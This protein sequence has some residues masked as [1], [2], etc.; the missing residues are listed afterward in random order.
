MKV[1]HQDPLDPLMEIPELTHGHLLA[2]VESTTPGSRP[3][4]RVSQAAAMV[5]RALAW[6][7]SLVTELRELGQAYCASR[8][9]VPRELPTNDAIVD[10]I[11]QLSVRGNG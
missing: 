10:L 6:P 2:L 7:D 1:D 9:Q 3:R 8:S 5:A 11:D 4:R